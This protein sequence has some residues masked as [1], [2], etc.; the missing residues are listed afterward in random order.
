M[1]TEQVAELESVAVKV[2]ARR[3]GIGRRLCLAVIDWCRAE[4]ASRG[5]VGSAC[6]PAVV[7]R[8]DYMRGWGLGELGCD[9]D[10]IGNR[11]MMLC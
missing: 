11:W 8:S 5:G 6:G 1:V 9:E 7:G 10:I 2:E 3:A 4:G